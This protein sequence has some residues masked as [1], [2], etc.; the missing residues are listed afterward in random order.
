[1]EKVRS[2]CRAS[3]CDQRPRTGSWKPALA[4]FAKSPKAF[5][6]GIGVRL[7][8]PLALTASILIHAALA[9]V[10]ILHAARVAPAYDRYVYVTVVSPRSGIALS[11]GSDSEKSSRQPTRD[12]RKNR[13]HLPR[14]HRAVRRITKNSPK[15]SGSAARAAGAVGAPSAA[16][17]MQRLANADA[18]NAR[19]SW[20]TE[21]NSAGV[22]TGD[23]RGR[24]S[25]GSVSGIVVSQAPV[26]LSSIVPDYPER[27]RALGIAGQV[28]LRFVVDQSG[29]VERDIKITTSI[30][31][32]DQ[33][34]IDAVRQWRF[35]PARDRD[36]NP[37]R[38]LVS[39]PLQFT[40][41]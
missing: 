13:R 2:L 34:A 15:S 9:V 1:M 26:L 14:R 8:I 5:R 21:G 30:P 16:P 17:A 22:A 31:L 36:G 24:A 20:K 11:N 38:V 4:Q 12:S 10:V 40:L 6:F 28:V 41:R 7:S 32:L 33:A 23:S 29:R 27:A 3:T 35:A 19:M 25:A 18:S 37:V 39:V